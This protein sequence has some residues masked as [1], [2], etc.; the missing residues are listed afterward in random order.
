MVC[1]T[2]SVLPNSW[3]MP[4]IIIS[5]NVMSLWKYKFEF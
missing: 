3:S 4:H 2:I 5:I 1:L